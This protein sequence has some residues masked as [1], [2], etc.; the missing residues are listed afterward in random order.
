MYVCVC[1]CVWR[2]RAPVSD[3]RG[4]KCAR[5]RR[6]RAR[7]LLLSL[8][9]TMRFIWRSSRCGR[10]RPA[11]TAPT[12]A[13]TV[14]WPGRS[15]PTP[16]YFYFY[17]ASEPFAIPT[18]YSMHYSPGKQLRGPESR[19]MSRNVG[20]LTLSTPLTQNHFYTFQVNIIIKLLWRWMMTVK[21]RFAAVRRHIDF[22][23]THLHVSVC[24]FYI[25]ILSLILCS[26]CCICVYVCI[27]SARS[28]CADA[29]GQW[30]R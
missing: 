27:P 10:A 16:F 24:T 3:P 17:S 8:L 2:A 29:V 14:A 28:T 21:C 6:P 11:S 13:P 26:V 1:A 25:L 23:L 5:R 4:G 20:P 22:Q 18:T 7:R 30:G 15:V 9:L 19:G 12:A